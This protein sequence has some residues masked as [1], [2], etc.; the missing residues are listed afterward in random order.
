ML[1]DEC[2]LLPK[3]NGPWNASISDSGENIL[4]HVVQADSPVESWDPVQ[5]VQPCRLFT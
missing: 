2:R 1:D 3:A 5:P 4:S